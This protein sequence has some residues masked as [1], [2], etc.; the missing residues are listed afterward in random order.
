MPTQNEQ[1]PVVNYIDLPYKGQPV[2]DSMGLQRE[3]AIR[4]VITM[5]LLSR[6]GD[7]GRDFKGGELL[8]VIGKGMNSITEEGIKTG[9]Y[10]ALKGYSNITVSDVTIIRDVEYKKWKITVYYTDSYNNLTD[11]ASVGIQQ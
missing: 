2:G 11:S 6:K 10:D 1:I 4:N 9:V 8:A 7:Y 5:R 3:V